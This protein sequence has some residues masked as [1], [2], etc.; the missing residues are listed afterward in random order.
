M[1]KE[2]DDSL[3]PLKNNEANNFLDKLKNST[4]K[5]LQAEAKTLKQNLK[6]NENDNAVLKIQHSYPGLVLFLKHAIA[7]IYVEGKTKYSVITTM[8]EE[9]LS[10]FQKIDVKTVQPI[11][12]ATKKATKKV[13]SKKY[14]TVWDLLR[15]HP[16]VIPEKWTIM[17]FV[18]IQKEN[19][20]ILSK[21]LSDLLKQ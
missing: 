20:E 4:N 21:V 17:N 3:E 15:K 19:S 2:N 1:A 7:E 18:F 12:K 5:L 9:I 10:K 16:I 8:N 6:N 11:K 13:S 14:I